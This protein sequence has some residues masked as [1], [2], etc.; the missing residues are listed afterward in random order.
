[1]TVGIID[2]EFAP[3]TSGKVP[4]AKIPAG[5]G[6]PSKKWYRFKPEYGT[7]LLVAIIVAY[8]CMTPIG[9]LLWVTFFDKGQFAPQNF[10]DAFKDPALP[11]LLFNTLAVAI[12]SPVTAQ[13]T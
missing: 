1:M 4:G 5:R 12:G 10:V 7:Y 3:D 9:Y 8:L 11:G 13:R 6:D 2:T